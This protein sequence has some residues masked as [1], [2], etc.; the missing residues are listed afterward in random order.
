MTDVNDLLRRVLQIVVSRPTDGLL[1]VERDAVK[2]ARE[3]LD[4]L[5]QKAPTSMGHG[6]L[7]P[8]PS[9]DPL[10]HVQNRLDRIESVLRGLLLFVA[11]DLSRDPTAPSGLHTH[12]VR[13]MPGGGCI[14][15]ALL[16]ELNDAD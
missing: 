14:V 5:E 12:T 7:C 6:S 9:C 3:Y 2:E 15:D 1:K 4:S 13:C 11:S 8:C 16:K 10:F